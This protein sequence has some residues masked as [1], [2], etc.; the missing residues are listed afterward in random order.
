[1]LSFRRETAEKRA[2]RELRLLPEEELDGVVDADDPGPLLVAG[3]Q[4]GGQ[5]QI[6][7]PDK[8]LGGVQVVIGVDHR[9]AGVVLAYHQ[10]QQGDRQTQG[11]VLAPHGAQIAVGHAAAADQAVPGHQI[12]VGGHH[13]DLSQIGAVAGAQDP[14]VLPGGGDGLQ[15]GALGPGGQVFH[16][17]GE[18]VIAELRGKLGIGLV[19]VVGLAGEIVQI[20]V[21]GYHDHGLAHPPLD[22][23]IQQVGQIEIPGV[24]RAGVIVQRPVEPE[25]LVGAHGVEQEQHVVGAALVV[26]VGQIDP[27]GLLRLRRAVGQIVPGGVAQVDDPPLFPGGLIEAAVQSG[28]DQ[29]RIQQ[30]NRGGRGRRRGYRGGRGRGRRGRRRRGC[31]LRKRRGLGRLHG[32]SRRGRISLGHQ[33]ADGAQNQQDQQGRQQDLLHHGV[34]PDIPGQTGESFVDPV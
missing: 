31:R 2:V 16:H 13:A 21:G 12:Q 23:L 25:A 20:V 14:K 15:I 8:G 28:V 30:G 27:H 1:M 10:I 3:L 11:A 7:I 9:L 6:L 17:A 29:G 34:S 19:R 24:L 33:N 18:N 5:A 4:N 26:A 22:Q 32:R